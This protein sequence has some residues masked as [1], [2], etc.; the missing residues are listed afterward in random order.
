[1]ENGIHV[2]RGLSSYCITG[3]VNVETLRKPDEK[4]TAYLTKQG[5]CSRTKERATCQGGHVYMG[6]LLLEGLLHGSETGMVLAYKPQN[7]CE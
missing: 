4:L 3:L 2:F 7:P 1:M 5:G 6:Q